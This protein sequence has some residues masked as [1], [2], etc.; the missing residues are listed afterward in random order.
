[1]GQQRSFL[2]AVSHDQLK[3]FELPPRAEIESV[4]RT[5][6]TYLSARNQTPLADP[7]KEQ[8]RVSRADSQYWLAAARLS[9]AL[10]SKLG[11][12]PP[13]QRIVLV[14][15][16]PLAYIPF[17]ALPAPG[18]RK[19]S[20]GLLLDTHEIVTLPSASILTALRAESDAGKTSLGTVAVVA[21]PVFDTADGRVRTD[22]FRGPTGTGFARLRF[23]RVE[24]EGILQLAPPARRLGA[25]DFD[26]S[27]QSVQ[28]GKI[29]DYRFVHFATHAVI[30]SRQPDRSAVVLA[31]VDRAGKPVDGLLRM[32]EIYNLRLNADTV[33]LS[34]CRTALGKEIRGEGLIALTRGFMQAGARR[35]VASL[36]SVED[37]ATSELMREFYRN[38]L[39]NRMTVAEALRRAKLH[40]RRDPR[41]TSPFYWAGFTVQGDWRN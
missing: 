19:N 7:G 31:M 39:T 4:A 37:R 24:A 8:Q 16:G 26:A 30:D 40:L 22:R 25:F 5:A 15:D 38:V 9:D 2:F 32:K 41:W 13:R 27:K 33:V 18:R 3:A 11:A 20:A 34:A 29:A 14:G 10:F 6:H 21:D 36:W 1:L 17:S 35:V 23:S 12:I 28:S